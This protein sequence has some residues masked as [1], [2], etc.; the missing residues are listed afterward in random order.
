[1][2][3]AELSRRVEKVVGYPPL[4]DMDDRQRRKF[5]SALLEA[6]NFEDLPGKR[7]AALP[8]RARPSSSARNA[9]IGPDAQAQLE[10]RSALDLPRCGMVARPTRRW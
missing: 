2:A 3:S 6:G 1:M 4:V 10:G 9:R 8:A 5:H 7:W